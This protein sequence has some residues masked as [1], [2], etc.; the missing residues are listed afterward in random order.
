MSGIG[1]VYVVQES[2]HLDYSDAERYGDVHFVT[3]TEYSNV[4]SAPRNEKVL[5]DLRSVFWDKFNPEHDYILMTGNP[6]TLG[7]A[8]HLALVSARR[9]SC[10]LRILRWDGQNGRYF[11][12]NFNEHF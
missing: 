4:D 1:R 10:P 2:N 5:K 9:K 3:S 6:I 11:Q 8:F 7:Y 12:I